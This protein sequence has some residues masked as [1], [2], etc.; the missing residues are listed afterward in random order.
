VFDLSHGFLHLS[1]LEHRNCDAALYSFGI[2]SDETASAKNPCKIANRKEIRKFL[3]GL[4][5]QG[6]FQGLAVKSYPFLHQ[7]MRKVN[8]TH[9]A[10]QT[11]RRK[12]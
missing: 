11:S 9:H 4:V 1:Y 12:T 6:D 2:A 10:L 7:V 8:A 3:I 5:D